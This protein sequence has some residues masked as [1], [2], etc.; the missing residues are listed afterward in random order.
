M[1]P[2]ARYDYNELVRQVQDYCVQREVPV[3][4]WRRQV[5]Q[6]EELAFHANVLR[7]MKVPFT[8]VHGSARFSLRRYN[9][10][11]DVDRIIEVFPGIVAN[12]RKLSP[13]WD[14]KTNAPRPDAED[15]LQKTH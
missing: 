12:L 4:R 5:N 8:A 15:S 14:T 1:S 2:V 6:E 10:E 3:P 7:A 9:T 13:Y 11:E